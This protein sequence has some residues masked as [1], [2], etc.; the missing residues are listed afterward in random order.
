MVSE[1]EEGEENEEMESEEDE[2]SELEE[3]VEEIEVVEEPT[4]A[5]DIGGDLTGCLTEDLIKEAKN[6]ADSLRSGHKSE[7]KALKTQVTESPNF[8]NVT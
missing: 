7:F 5:A 1:N 8:T 4:T 6:I 2:L 3:A